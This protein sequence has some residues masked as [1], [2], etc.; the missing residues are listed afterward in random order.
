M[1]MPTIHVKG[2]LPTA[3]WMY[4]HEARPLIEQLQN[5]VRELEQ[6][7]QPAAQDEA[8]VEEML[9]AYWKHRNWEN[10]TQHNPFRVVKGIYF[11]CME[12]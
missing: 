9:D 8:V 1:T 4:E 10:G 7:D 11:N 5:R 12:K 3:S 2:T 6:R